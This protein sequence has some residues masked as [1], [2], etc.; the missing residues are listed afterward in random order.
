M[1]HDLYPA[2]AHRFHAKDSGARFTK[3]AALALLDAAIWR[4]LQMR[5]QAD[6][7]SDEYTAILDAGSTLARAHTQV[8]HA[9]VA[10]TTPES[11]RIVDMPEADDDPL[12]FPVFDLDGTG[13][14][15][16]EESC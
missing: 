7:G 13:Q 4:V 14:N 9:P 8:E 2:S 5:A 15:L 16:P 6:P 12:T 10:D 3:P 1:T 11:V